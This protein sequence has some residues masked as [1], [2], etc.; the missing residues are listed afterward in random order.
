MKKTFPLTDPK[1]HEDRVLEAI[2]HEVR[3]YL[4]RERGKKLSDKATMYWDF[5]CRVGASKEEAQEVSLA[6]LTSQFDVIKSSGAKTLY[7]EILAKEV[8]K[9][10]KSEEEEA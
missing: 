6:E 7:V 10:L 2:K 1:K 9:P 3:K 5:D 4:K 8:A